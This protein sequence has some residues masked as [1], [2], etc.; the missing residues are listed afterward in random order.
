MGPVSRTELLREVLAHPDEMEPRL[1]FADWLQQNGEAERGELICI[2]CRLE[3]AEPWSDQQVALEKR[4]TELLRRYAST[5]TTPISAL[6]EEARWRRGFVENVTVSVHRP[7]LPQLL[8]LEPVRVVRWRRT[9]DWT[10]FADLGRS[11]Y[12]D[13]LAGIELDSFLIGNALAELLGPGSRVPGLRSLWL[14]GNEWRGMVEVLA[15]Q[16]WRRLEELELSFNNLGD[17]ELAS[18]V[19]A[20][21]LGTLRCLRFRDSGIGD[22]V[23]EAVSRATHLASLTDLR[24]DNVHVRGY[25]R[26]E[27]E[28]GVSARGVSAMAVA[29]HLAGLRYLDLCGHRLGPEGAVELAAAECLGSLRILSLAEGDP[30]VGDAG[31]RAMAASPH[32]RGLRALSLQANAITDRG[33]AALLDQGVF[34]ALR[35]LQLAGNDLSDSLL[36]RLRER[37]NR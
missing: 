20:K 10:R 22:L 7:A 19:L 16:P 6:V 21:Q 8:A 37:Y 15:A 26:R 1:V 31:L 27:P 30:G 35:G 3:D 9:P 13:Q 14:A 33:A 32:L 17:G 4:R 12:L 34:P 28:A 11:V 24:I 23:A 18:L 29:P 2:D 25:R 5:W 36:V